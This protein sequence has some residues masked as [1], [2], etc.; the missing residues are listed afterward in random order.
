MNG[1]RFCKGGSRAVQ[2]VENESA[3]SFQKELKFLQEPCTV[4][5]VH[6]SGTCVATCEDGIPRV[7][8]IPISQTPTDACHP[9]Q[10][11]L[12]VLD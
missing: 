9:M 2:P 6:V 8:L 1:I 10:Y 5:L 12:L 7:V 11:S 3:L 4:T